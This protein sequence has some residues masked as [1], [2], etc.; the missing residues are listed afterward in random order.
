M[1]AASLSTQG[2]LKLP[3][4]SWGSE[5]VGQFLS[6]QHTLCL[7]GADPTARVRVV[8]RKGQTNSERFC[9]GSVYDVCMR[10]FG[11]V[12]AASAHRCGD[13]HSVTSV[14]PGRVPAGPSAGGAGREVRGAPGSRWV[15]KA[16]LSALAPGW[17]RA[18]S[19]SRACSSACRQFPLLLGRFYPGSWSAMSSGGGFGCLRSFPYASPGYR[20][21][22]RFA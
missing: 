22:S 15:G 18:A 21:F 14:G 11:W 16:P 5:V 7:V 6:S 1:G 19:P 3:L 8:N 2:W 12:G 17:G 13:S 10:C 20:I 4:S 9:G